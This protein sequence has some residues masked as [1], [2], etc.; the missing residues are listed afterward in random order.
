MQQREKLSSLLMSSAQA[1]Q[2]LYGTRGAD[3][4]RKRN[5]PHLPRGHQEWCPKPSLM[6]KR[7]Y[8]SSSLHQRLVAA[9]GQT[10]A[11]PPTLFGAA[12]PD[13]NEAAG[14]RRNG[15]FAGHPRLQ[16]TCLEGAQ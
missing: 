2:K 14:Q 12:V 6:R 1:E 8:D 16:S 7:L 10:S 5:I 13:E 15:T 11:A 3:A 4:A 9:L